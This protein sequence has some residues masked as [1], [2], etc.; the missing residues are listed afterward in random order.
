M[1][2]VIFFVQK[3]LI[4]FLA[5][6]TFGVAI[7][8]RVFPAFAEE[9]DFFDLDDFWLPTS[10]ESESYSSVFP[11]QNLS[12]IPVSEEIS[13]F[14][15]DPF[16]YLVG[17]RI[18]SSHSHEDPD[19]TNFD[20]TR[21]MVFSKEELGRADIEITVTNKGLNMA[22]DLKI[23]D[24]FSGA[25]QKFFFDFPTSCTDFSQ[26]LTCSF[27]M[28]SVGQTLHIHYSVFLFP[29]KWQAEEVD[30]TVLSRTRV[31]CAQEKQEEE[32][33]LRQ[34][35]LFPRGV[36]FSKDVPFSFQTSSLFED[37][38]SIGILRFSLKNNYPFSSGDFVAFLPLPDT[39]SVLQTST[40]GHYQKELHAI[41]FSEPNVLS[42]RV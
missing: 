10:E 12:T 36:L 1:R 26:K 5:V 4:F 9:D 3:A 8:T 6:F 24:Y 19:S 42:R 37:G 40:N 23:E 22:T 38:S 41:F 32:N 35:T 33:V 31:S 2:K 7:F 39:V 11:D 14:S 27:P 16:F 17:Q 21:S 15:S 28:L 20:V 25:E 34:Q 18:V 29:M 13:T 30:L